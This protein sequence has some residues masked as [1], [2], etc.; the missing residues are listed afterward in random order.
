[1]LLDFDKISQK[2]TLSWQWRKVKQSLRRAEQTALYQ[3]HFK[4]HGVIIKKIN[5]WQDFATIPPTTEADFRRHYRKI[6]ALP[7]EKI[8][9]IF[10]T[11][12]TTGESKL[13]FR[14]PITVRSELINV[15]QTL[16]R[17]MDYWP[18]LA[19]IMRPAG[20]LGASGPVS[21][22]MMELLK[23]P[24]F[25]VSSESDLNQTARALLL[26]KPDLIIASPSFL[27]QLTYFFKKQQLAPRSIGIRKVITTGERLHLNERKYLQRELGAEIFNV[28]GAA[29]PSVWIGSECCYHRGLHIFPQTA[30]LE[31]SSQGNLIVTS[32]ANRAMPLIRYQLSD[33]VK[34][35]RRVCACGSHLPR[36]ISISREEK[37]FQT[38]QGKIYFK[39][40]IDRLLQNFPMVTSFFQLV[41]KK[42]K[43]S[44]AI[45]ADWL[46]LKNKEATEK[47]LAT[48]IEKA[49][50]IKKIKVNIIEIGSLKRQASKLTKQVVVESFME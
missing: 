25:T 20:G 32:F 19:A 37:P 15:W 24:C 49:L 17:R 12:G 30:Y 40:E 5:N 2:K 34:F 27:T 42:D 6:T 14:E 1:M 45:E 43:A 35:N 39:K 46:A 38:S 8:W 18:R 7:L 26:I 36:I 4:R 21:A 29:D 33:K 23:I 3:N 11:S 10:A 41:L 48:E 13:I 22:K 28:Y 9:R 44:L 31:T 16:F 50:K 47:K